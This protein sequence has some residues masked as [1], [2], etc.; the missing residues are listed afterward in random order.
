MFKADY[1]NT[2]YVLYIII[3]NINMH[4][5]YDFLVKN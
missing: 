2:I 5:I 3:D 1:K 4:Y